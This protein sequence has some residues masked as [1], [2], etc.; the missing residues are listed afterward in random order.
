MVDMS[1]AMSEASFLRLAKFLSSAGLA[2]EQLRMAVVFAHSALLLR[3]VCNA[4]HCATNE[5]G[6]AFQEKLLLED[7]A[8][9]SP[10]AKEEVD[11]WLDAMSM[12]PPTIS[13]N[14]YAV[15]NRS[16]LLS[17]MTTMVTYLVV[18]V[19]FNQSWKSNTPSNS[20]EECKSVCLILLILHHF[21]LFSFEIFTQFFLI[22]FSPF[23]VSHI[24]VSR[25]PYDVNF[26]F[27]DTNNFRITY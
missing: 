20:S 15:V 23:S 21:I 7:I 6:F 13:L 8:S 11:R 18:L 24:P 19:Q 12:T 10:Q 14:G 26:K 22:L 9:R 1:L 27:C 16:M 4:A 3:A 25:N 5:V 17:I 2:L